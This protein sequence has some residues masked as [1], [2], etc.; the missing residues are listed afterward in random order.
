MRRFAFAIMTLCFSVSLLARADD[1][2]RTY[3]ISGTP[4]LRIETTDANI[5]VDTWDQ[6]TIEAHI[7][8][9]HYKIGEGGIKV[10]DHQSGDA[11]DIEVR[12]PHT[13]FHFGFNQRVDVDIHMPREG[14]VNLRTGDG[15]IRLSGLKGAMELESGDGGEDINGVDG[16]LRA[17]TG[18][19][20]IRAEGR[21]DQLDLSSGDG[22]VDA[23]AMAGS[24]AA[25]DWSIRTGDGSVTL[26]VPDNFAADVN[27]H[28]GDGHIS[29]DMPVTVEGSLKNN[30]IRG[31]LNGGGSQLTI[32]TGD[33]SIR[34]EK[35]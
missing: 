30:D 25:A 23:R 26:Q 10:S 11:V 35:S 17:H 9:S 13:A 18:D 19:G 21:F 14:R 12:F 2:S 22:R 33:G 15:E 5:H 1:W 20:H 34:L 31:K 32:H 8:T 29:L 7:T 16:N 3:N 6:K 24:K 28:T 27:L 4:E